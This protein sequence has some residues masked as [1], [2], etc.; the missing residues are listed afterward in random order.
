MDLND[1][2]GIRLC[3]ARALDEAGGF[4]VL[5]NNAGSGVYWPADQLSR[6]KIIEQFQSMVFAPMELTRLLLPGMRARGR[7]LVVNITSLASLF[8]IPYMGAYNACKAAMSALSWTLEMELCR[9]PIRVVEVR[10][11]DIRTDFHQTMERHASLGDADA[12][13]NIVRAYRAYTENMERAPS[14]ERVAR[15]VS[16]LVDREGW[17]PSRINV[18]S[19]FQARIAPLLSNVSPQAWTRFVLAKYYRLKCGRT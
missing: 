4:D 10:P 19:T 8:P 1:P 9:E 6:E 16:R 18:G 5:I 15:L 2:D 13:E 14:P 11:G 3:V 12:D 7:G 17:L